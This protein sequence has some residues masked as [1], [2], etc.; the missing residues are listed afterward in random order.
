MEYLVVILFFAL[1]IG[2][3]DMIRVVNKNLKRQTALL[4]KIHDEMKKS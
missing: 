4:Q 1:F 3:Y 2:M